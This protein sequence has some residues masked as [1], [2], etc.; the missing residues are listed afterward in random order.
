[1]RTHTRQPG[2]ASGQS[3]FSLV[4][5]LIVVILIVVLSAIALPSLLGQLRNQKVRGAAQE[6][7][8]AVQTARA[9][10]IMKNV[11]SSVVFGVIDQDTYSFL[12]EDAPG[13]GPPPSPAPTPVAE[14][15]GPLSHLPA[16]VAFVNTGNTT[17]VRFDRMGR[18]LP[19]APVP[20]IPCTTAQTQLCDDNPGLP[21]VSDT[22]T[23]TRIAVRDFHTEVE[24]W[25][26]VTPGG[27]VNVYAKH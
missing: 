7:A 18:R 17:G 24:W 8:S 16:G 21:Y 13:G 12:I 6:V 22:T 14:Q 20:A 5:S 15:L 19:P 2:A 23:G 27:R 11:N 25:V 1:M 3:G 4:E 9:K 26:D 10:A